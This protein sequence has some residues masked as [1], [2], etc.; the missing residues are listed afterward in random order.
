MLLLLQYATDQMCGNIK[1]IYVTSLVTLQPHEITMQPRDVLLHTFCYDSFL[2]M[3][4]FYYSTYIARGY[5][6]IAKQMLY[7]K[8]QPSKKFS[9]Q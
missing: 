5:E 7:G 4:V 1:E 2:L 9:I 6:Y 3:H 8:I